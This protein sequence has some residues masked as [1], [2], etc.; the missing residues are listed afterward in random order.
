MKKAASVVPANSIGAVTASTDGSTDEAVRSTAASIAASIDDRIV[1]SK[2]DAPATTGVD[3][4]S[5]TRRAGSGFSAPDQAFPHRIRLCFVP[6]DHASGISVPVTE[7]GRQ[8]HACE[9]LDDA[10]NFRDR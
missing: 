1:V 7:L 2:P 3:G 10:K 4:S 6:C 5:L 9:Q 8:R